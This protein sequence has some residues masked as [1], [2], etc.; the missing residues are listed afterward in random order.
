MHSPI[1]NPFIPF[2]NRGN[3]C[4]DNK[5]SNLGHR[6]PTS[7]IAGAPEFI[8]I[9]SPSSPSMFS[10]LT[11]IRCS[12]TAIGLPPSTPDRSCYACCTRVDH[13]W[14]KTSFQ[15]NM[16]H[17]LHHSLHRLHVVRI[18]NTHT[19]ITQAKPQRSI[20][21]MMIKKPTSKKVKDI[22]LTPYSVV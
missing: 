17:L 13:W 12:S 11:D 1:E 16:H 18:R 2:W 6:A 8:I 19:K 20:V 5:H 21:A 10:L 7:N 22:P 4:S 3:R 14:C 9:P 15:P